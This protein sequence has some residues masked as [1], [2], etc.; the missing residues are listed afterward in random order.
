MHV[1]LEG[2]LKILYASTIHDSSTR[3]I[4]HLPSNSRMM[5][6][7][8]IHTMELDPSSLMNDAQQRAVNTDKFTSNRWKEKK[9]NRRVLRA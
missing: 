3:R 1:L 9:P 8:D 5:R 4:L 6:S 7:M 2:K